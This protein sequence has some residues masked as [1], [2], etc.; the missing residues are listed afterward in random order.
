MSPGCGEFLGTI[1]RMLDR[2]LGCLLRHVNNPRPFDVTGPTAGRLHRGAWSRKPTQAPSAPESDRH[3]GHAGRDAWAGTMRSRQRPVVL[4]SRLT[5]DPRLARFWK[6]R[7]ED[8]LRREKQLLI[9]LPFCV[10]RRAP[11][12]CR[13]RHEDLAQ[14]DGQIR[15]LAKILRN[16]GHA[17]QLQGSCRRAN[18]G[19]GVHR[20][21]RSAT[22]W[23]R[24]DASSRDPLN[25]CGAVAL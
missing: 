10:R 23:S 13:P 3:G 8:G 9:D 20:Q 5:K 1:P 17:R 25:A 4:L 15:R 14:G 18:R 19:A 2:S 24:A 21:T 16:R 11:A 22:S 12:L 7:G 6:N